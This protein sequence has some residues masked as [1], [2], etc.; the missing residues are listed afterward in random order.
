[1]QLIEAVIKPQKLDD[2]KNA[3]TRSRLDPTRLVLEV[4]ETVLMDEVLAVANLH[5]LQALGV[6]ISIDDFGTGYNSI[7]RLKQLPI[8]VIKIDRT[9]LD[10]SD[11]SA[12]ALLELIVHTAHTFGLPVVAEG[13]ET[14]AQLEVL[15]GLGCDY[16]Q[17][18]LLSRPL[19]VDQVEE[20]IGGA[21]GTRT[22]DPHTAG[23]GTRIP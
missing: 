23:T 15:T 18:Y 8:D 6:V 16:V 1:M 4:T 14:T 11:R 22:P 12:A 17:G 2:V 10:A 9:F 19:T 7:T 20:S 3:L 21:E 5:Q 13:V